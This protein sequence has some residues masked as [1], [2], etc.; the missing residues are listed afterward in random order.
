MDE[1]KKNLW[2][3]VVGKTT[4]GGK[5]QARTGPP[6]TQRSLGGP[7]SSGLSAMCG[8]GVVWAKINSLWVSQIESLRHC[9]VCHDGPKLT[10]SGW[11]KFSHSGTVYA[12]RSVKGIEVDGE[13]KCFNF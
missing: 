10:I 6:A 4:G 3:L 13:Q 7:L 1:F 8:Y 5:T 12:L 11:A 2:A 9:T